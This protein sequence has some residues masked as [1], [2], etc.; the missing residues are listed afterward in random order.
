MTGWT[1]E[2]G[3]DDND[4]SLIAGSWGTGG[5]GWPVSAAAWRVIA[6]T[7]MWFGLFGHNQPDSPAR[8]P[9]GT[10]ARRK[11]R[12]EGET[13]ALISV[14]EAGRG[15]GEGGGGCVHP[16]DPTFKPEQIAGR[17]GRH[18]QGSK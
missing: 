12:R 8:P 18:G 3:D 11:G 1:A 7:R 13:M 9:H 4:D 2:L 15:K 10:K 17:D 14:V 5:Y 6:M 16:A